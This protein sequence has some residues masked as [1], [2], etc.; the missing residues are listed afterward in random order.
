MEYEMQQR[1]QT[2]F[3]MVNREPGFAAMARKYEKLHRDFEQLVDTYPVEEQDILWAFVCHSED[4]NWRM[5]EWLCER[6]DIKA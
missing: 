1:I 5:L 4:M 6:Y 2:L 3:R